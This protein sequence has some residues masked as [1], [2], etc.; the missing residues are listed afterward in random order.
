MN[1][2]L[3]KEEHQIENCYKMGKVLMIKDEYDNALNK[4]TQFCKMFQSFILKQDQ[5]PG[6]TE[7]FC[8]S[9]YDIGEIYLKKKQSRNNNTFAYKM[10]Y[11]YI[12]LILYFPFAISTIFFNL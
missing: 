7:M 6:K 1:D 4:Y 10:V 5:I 12:F 2:D 11:V 3:L 8:A 9:L